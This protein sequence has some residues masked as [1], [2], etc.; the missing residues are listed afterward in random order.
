MIDP[1]TLHHLNEWQG[2]DPI[3]D[4]STPIVVEPPDD[5]NTKDEE[6][7]HVNNILSVEELTEE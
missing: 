7:N 3:S 6:M 4:G 2:V 1:D 5:A